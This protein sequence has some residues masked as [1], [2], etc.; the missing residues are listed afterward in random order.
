M[1]VRKSDW[2]FMNL[3]YIDMDSVRVVRKIQSS[4]TLTPETGDVY[5]EEI[6]PGPPFE[7]T[8]DLLSQ[9]IGDV[10]LSSIII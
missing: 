9:I 4:I 6:I 2:D 8:E 10:N 1:K 5:K 7:E 3:K